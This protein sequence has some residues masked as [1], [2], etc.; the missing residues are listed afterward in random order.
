MEQVF[1]VFQIMLHRWL[2]LPK[3]ILQ[4]TGLL[5]GG[6][7]GEGVGGW[8]GSAGVRHRRGGQAISVWPWPGTYVLLH[9]MERATPTPCSTLGSLL[10]GWGGMPG[11][12]RRPVGERPSQDRCGKC[13]PKGKRIW[14][15]GNVPG[16]RQSSPSFPWK[17]LCL[18]C[19]VQMCLD[20]ISASITLCKCR[21][22]GEGAPVSHS[23]PSPNRVCVMMAG[24]G[25]SAGAG[26]SSPPRRGAW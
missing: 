22:W 15:R 7:G 17:L 26:D 6:P 8:G 24:R 12:S 10:W 21:P 3:V 5:Q 11:M 23:I 16:K 2:V 9:P 4:V 25:S 1:C 20:D 13:R 18:K 14:L 19:K